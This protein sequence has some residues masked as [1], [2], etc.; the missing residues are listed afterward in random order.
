V[1]KS[2]EKPTSGGL[3]NSQLVPFDSLY[4]DPNNPRIAPEEPPGYE[5]P[6]AIFD[7]ELQTELEA[8]VRN[9]YKVANLETSIEAQG[10]VPYDPIIVWEH[11][12]KKGHYIVVEGNTRTVALRGLRG[13]KLE[14]ESKKLDKLKKSPSRFAEE[15]KVQAEIVSK[16]E[17][18]VEATNELRV[19]PIAANSVAQLLEELPRLL[20]VRHI[21]HA[22]SWGPY[23]TN[24]YILLQYERLF[25]VRY[26]DKPQ[27]RLEQD[28]IK[29]VAALVSLG[30]TKTRR[31]IQ[32]ASA[33]THFKRDFEDRL[34]EGEEFGDDDHYYFEL[35]LQNKYPQDQFGFG[36]DAL[37]LPAESEE[38]L[39]TWAFSKP[40]HLSGDNEADDD[41]ENVFYKR[42]NI[43]LWQQ[44]HKY[45]SEKGTGFSTQLD[46]DDPEAA[47]PMR[48]I[49][50]DFLQHKTRRSPVDSIAALIKALQELKVDTLVSQ[51]D[52]LEP[53]LDEA[54]KLIE[55]YK[56]MMKAATATG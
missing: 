41:N 54:V 3:L 46:I 26:G 15:L 25:R 37:R 14:R 19:Y 34:S 28:L 11:P 10:W 7:T 16:L 22:Q 45:D 4:L 36:K 13:E 1:A 51:Q 53:M 49:E 2:P 42:E 12:K 30:E 56:R 40:R 8:R 18:I 52:H 20:G 23:A 6:N 32:A 17:A 9:A 50:A 21:N 35:I 47:R 5:D 33:F 44:L 24:L 38:A 29:A 55:K 31:S 27:L 48:Q 39:F 43:R